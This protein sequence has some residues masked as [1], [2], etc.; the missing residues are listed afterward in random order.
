MARRPTPPSRRKPPRRPAQTKNR[1][2]AAKSGAA[3]DAVSAAPAASNV[4]ERLDVARAQQLVI[5]MMA[6]PGG[7]G[8]EERIASFVVEALSAAGLPDSAIAFDTAHRRS[9][10]GGKLGNLIVKL[11]GSMPGP[12][13]LLAAHLDTVP[14]CIGAKPVRRGNIVTS[15]DPA[16]GLGGDN[17]AGTAVL[18]VAALEI[19]KRNLPHPPLTLLWFVQEEVGLQ[20]SH[21]VQT[22]L[23]GKPK[24]A[25]NFDGGGSEKLTLGA[26][27]GYRMTIEIQGI[28]SHAGGAPEAGVSAIAIASLAIAELHQQGWH[29]LISKPGP[30]GKTLLGTSN[31]GV[32]H[33]GQA[34]NVVTDRVEIKAEARSHDP[35]FRE[36]IVRHITGA[37]ER[38]AKAVRNTAGQT[39]KAKV[40]GR[41][42]YESFVLSPSEPSVVAAENAVRAAGGKPM[43]AISNGGLDA[44]WLSAHGIP[45]VTLGCGQKNIHTT[46]EQL[47]LDEFIRACRVGLLLAT[48][49]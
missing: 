31:V 43:H 38:A 44:N 2:T 13:R 37:F 41:L 24:L 30:R 45:T 42:D 27:G 10:L 36:Q 33:G 23:L 32:F 15:S 5:D 4:A 11:P 19:L 20:G 1:P 12:R 17:R 28:A 39:G 7:S 3:T 22:S 18:L 25:F 34:T 14:I 29:G 40:E 35:R 16:T 6:I 9:P 49:V 46:D 8:D 47:D 26:T 21:Y 48:G